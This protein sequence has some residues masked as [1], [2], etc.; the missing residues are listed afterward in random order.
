M[1]IKPLKI[2]RRIF[3]SFTWNFPNEKNGIF[4]T[5]DDG[6]TPDVTPWVLDILDKY[7]AKATFFCIGR[8][9]ERHP[10]IYKEIL[11]RGHAVGNHSYSHVKNWTIKKEDYVSDIYLAEDLIDSNLY[12]PPYAIMGPDKAK[13]VEGRYN[14]I[15]WSVVSEDY[16]EKITGEECAAKVIPHIAPGE[17]IV[18]H[19]SVKCSSVLYKALP[20]VLDAIKGKGLEC[21]KIDL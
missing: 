8:N 11:R 4:L 3:A 20:M 9:V 6:P 13:M 2:I 17:I 14:I 21:K 18:F 12:R 10:D 5:F 19:D 1:R 15:M 7:N 16:K